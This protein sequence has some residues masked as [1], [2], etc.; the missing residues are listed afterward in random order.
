MVTYKTGINETDVGLLGDI[1]KRLK[2]I[3]SALKKFKCSFRKKKKM[4]F[5][6]FQFCYDLS[7]SYSWLPTQEVSKE[8]LHRRY[9]CKYEHY[10]QRVG[11]K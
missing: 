11:A 3:N 7:L 1:Y 6:L 5:L 2:I 4:Q 10:I 8:E 9:L